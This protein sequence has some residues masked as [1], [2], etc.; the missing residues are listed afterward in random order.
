VFTQLYKNV[1]VA[2]WNIWLIK[3]I[4][5]LF[6][7]FLPGVILLVTSTKPIDRQILEKTWEYNEA[8]HQLFIGFEKAY[9]SIR[10]EIL[11]NI[12]IEFGVSM[13]LVRLIKICLNETSSRV[14][15]G[16]H[17]SGRFPIRNGL[18]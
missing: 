14:R 3:F 18:K 9:D 12:L 13:K 8:V 15:V 16:K 11:Y 10:R 2:V 6:S 7:F 17:L 4:A 5:R 1:L